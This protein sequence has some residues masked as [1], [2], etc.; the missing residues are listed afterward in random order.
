MSRGKIVDNSIT[1]LQN[2][3]TFGHQGLPGLMS[4]LGPAPGAFQ[5]GHIM[6][7]SWL[8]GMYENVIL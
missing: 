5:N 6:T 7:V 3:L 2:A 1:F 8:Q 4:Q